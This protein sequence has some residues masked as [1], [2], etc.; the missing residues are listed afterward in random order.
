[1]QIN[2]D[3]LSVSLCETL[4]S[5]KIKDNCG[6]DVT[7]SGVIAYFSGNV[8]SI[9]YDI[10]NKFEPWIGSVFNENE[11]ITS[12]SWCKGIES[13]S[14]TPLKLLVTDKTGSIYLL[15]PIT[16][17]GLN[18]FKLDGCFATKIL[19]HNSST[20]HFY[21]VTSKSD[22]L[23]FCINANK[24]QLVWNIKMNFTVDFFEI[25]PYNGRE[26]LAASKTGSFTFIYVDKDCD[27]PEITPT[28]T[29]T[30]K[31]VDAKYYPFLNETVSFITS[32][33]VYLYNASKNAIIPM[34]FFALQQDPLITV[35][36]PDPKNERSLLLVHQNQFEYF[37]SDNIELTK[38][39]RVKFLSPFKKNSSSLSTFY[40]NNKFYVFGSGNSLQLFELIKGSFWCTKI[41]RNISIAPNDFDCYQPESKMCY[42]GNNGV[43]HISEGSSSLTKVFQLQ[44]YSIKQVKWVSSSQLLLVASLKQKIVETKPKYR[45]RSVSEVILEKSKNVF[46]S[47][48]ELYKSGSNSE[49]SNVTY[50]VFLLDIQNAT[51]KSLLN[52]GIEKI[53]NDP[54]I[55]SISPS[56]RIASIFVGGNFA[57]FYDFEKVEKSDNDINTYPRL[58]LRLFTDEGSIGTFYTDFDFWIFCCNGRGYKIKIDPKRDEFSDVVRFKSLGKGINKKS[59][60]CA[61][62]GDYLC[63]GFEN[64]DFRAYDFAENSIFHQGLND[65]AITS[66]AVSAD[67]SY[68]YISGAS[69]PATLRFTA[70]KSLESI[71]YNSSKIVFLS[72]HE[73]LVKN[74]NKSSLTL[75]SSQKLTPKKAKISQYIQNFEPILITSDARKESIIP[76]A[77]ISL[78]EEIKLLRKNMFYFLADILCCLNN[79]EFYPLACGMNLNEERIKHYLDT[80]CDFYERDESGKLN[81]ERVRID[82]LRDNN[83]D[84]FNILMS[85]PK[86]DPNYVLNLIKASYLNSDDLNFTRCLAPS[87]AALI[88][89]G[90]LND[91]IDILLLTRQFAEASRQLIGDNNI[92]NALAIAKTHMPH[93]EFISTID[94]VVDSYLVDKKIK[95]AVS[96]LVACNLMDKAITLLENS[97]LYFSASFLNCIVKENE[98]YMFDPS[99]FKSA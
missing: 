45:Q 6:M 65:S 87:I 95:A 28:Q 78:T 62:V 2:D 3:S 54:P 8:I 63:I 18:M 84:A 29:F 30:K 57:C 80:L 91:A 55:L 73:L 47:K 24:M 61:I 21:V 13:D 27:N 36:F 70:E 90:K 77:K 53:S 51:F 9:Y 71:P 69:A 74:P 41:S 43:I 88:A 35:Y 12:I 72:S 58:F 81:I 49:I 50:K 32:T 82:L 11:P 56:Y 34:F 60:A 59:T 96:L 83:K 44:N 89:G 97:E 4:V 40:L 22:I 19:W 66:I 38:P 20:K 75:C 14:E 99:K 17:K 98:I 46:G 48:G 5:S 39:Q 93:D 1:M 52:P 7:P 37:K 33:C 25:S 42:V 64:G 92:P 86:D 85:T 16:R 26:L 31:L 15:D 23:L 94:L 10:G 67:R 76:K 79:E 68:C